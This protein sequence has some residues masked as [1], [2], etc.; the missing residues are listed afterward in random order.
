MEMYT[1][2]ITKSLINPVPRGRH[3]SWKF[4]VIIKRCWYAVISKED[5]FHLESSQGREW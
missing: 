5:Y 1:S 2:E 3:F 4:M